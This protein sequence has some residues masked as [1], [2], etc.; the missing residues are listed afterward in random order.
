MDTH[1]SAAINAPALL[2]FGPH[3][4]LQQQAQLLFQ[5]IFCP[6]QGCGICP[7]CT[8]ITLK[9]H[10]AIAW[11]RPEK[12][13][14]I[15]QVD[16]IL[17]C[18]NFAQDNHFFIVLEQAETLTPATANRLLK[19]LEEP[20]AGYHFLLLAERAYAVLPTIRSRCLTKTWAAAPQQSPYSHLINL[21][22]AEHTNPNQLLTLLEENPIPETQ[23]LMVLDEILEQ[24]I[25][26]RKK[27]PIPTHEDQVIATLTKAFEYP[28]MPGSGKLF[29]KNLYLQTRG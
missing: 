6:Q 19:S 3:E 8:K 12:Q 7:E 15:E 9:Q 17:K 16:E 1:T 29:W 4:L 23:T 14:L 13:Y 11:F 22:M 20:P 27:A 5:K 25:L 28:P 2:W 24:W 21:F 10:H 26:R 18:L